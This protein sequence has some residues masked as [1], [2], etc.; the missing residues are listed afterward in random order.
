MARGSVARGAVAAATAAEVAA[1][2]A[3]KKDLAAVEPHVLGV[4]MKWVSLVS[5]TLQRRRHAGPAP[6]PASVARLSTG[7]RGPRRGL[8]RLAGPSAD[9][10]A[11]EAQERASGRAA[12]RRRASPALQRRRPGRGRH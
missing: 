11:G 6:P 10:P 7:P 2:A 3:C 9:G 1:A 12:R 4:P 5:L 8:R